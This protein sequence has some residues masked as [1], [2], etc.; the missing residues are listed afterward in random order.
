MAAFL[1]RQDFDSLTIDLQH[2]LIDY[3]TSL[4]MLQAVTVTGIPAICRV[5]WNDPIPVMKA[6]DAGFEGIICPMINNREEAEEE[7]C[8][9]PLQRRS[10][11]R[12]D[13]SAGLRFSQSIH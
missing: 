11:R 13:A 2:G 12:R 7:V 5:P 3:Q 8:W 1:A 6:L 4:T 9:Y 10:G